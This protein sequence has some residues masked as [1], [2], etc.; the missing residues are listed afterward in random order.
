MT[1]TEKLENFDAID[2]VSSPLQ[3]AV[4]KAVPNGS[5]LK[6]ALSGTWLQHPVHPPL[7][8]VVIGSW[9]SGVAVDMLGGRGGA[10]ASRR[11]VGLGILAALPTAATGASDWSDLI[12]KDRRLGSI[13]AVANSTALAAQSLSWLERRRGHRGRGIALSLAAVGISSAAAWIGGHLSY[14]RAVGVNHTAFE[15]GPE[16]WTRAL[17]ASKLVEGRLIGGL[18]PEGFE[19]LLVKRGETIHAMADR[20]AHMGCPLHEGEL[21]G[22]IVRCGCHGSEFTLAGELVHGPATSGQP[23]FEARI[24]GEAVEVRKARG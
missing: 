13:H 11:L 16:E 14:G 20:C 12:G 19:V 5:R 6:D 18:T 24:A 9:L 23:R 15:E 2:R 4:S 7:T 21:D 10:T 8:D 1:I 3:D 17:D 22:Q